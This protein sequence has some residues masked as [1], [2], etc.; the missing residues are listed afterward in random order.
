MKVVGD[1]GIAPHFFMPAD[2]IGFGA[3]W[4][5]PDTT[6]KDA[7]ASYLVRWQFEIGK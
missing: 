6:E 3:R 7:K 5:W 2:Y 1:L 4:V